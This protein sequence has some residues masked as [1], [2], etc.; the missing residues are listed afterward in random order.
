MIIKTVLD[1]PRALLSDYNDDIA[2]FSDVYIK[3]FFSPISIAHIL[4]HL[5]F[6][7]FFFLLLKIEFLSYQN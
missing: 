4:N 7:L 5:E 6:I 1:G 3:L 2:Y